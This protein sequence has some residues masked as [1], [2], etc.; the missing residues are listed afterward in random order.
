MP[1]YRRH[2]HSSSV[3]MMPTLPF[4]HRINKV[5]P[6]AAGQ[7]SRRHEAALQVLVYVPCRKQPTGLDLTVCSFCRQQ[8]QELVNHLTDEKKIACLVV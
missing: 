8:D 1:M 7:G 6:Q 2:A 5:I 4:C 3:Y